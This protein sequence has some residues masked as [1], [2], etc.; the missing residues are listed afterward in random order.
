VTVPG[1]RLEGWDQPVRFGVGRA[2]EIQ[3]ELSKLKRARPLVLC[4]WR[5]ARS[6]DLRR[7]VGRLPAAEVFEGV[8]DHVPGSALANAWAAIE[9]HDA[10]AVISFGGGS[11]IDLGKSLVYLGNEGPAAFEA[12]APARVRLHPRLAHVALPTTY[13]G[14]EATRRCW[15]SDRDVR[16]SL[17]GLATRPDLVVADPELTLGL[18]A[19]PTAATGLGALAH[20]LEALCSWGTSA[21]GDAAA[22]ASAM[23]LVRLLPAVVADPGRVA[24][25][26]DL[27]A[28]SVVAGA[29]SDQGSMG[30]IH[31]VSHGLAGRSGVP[32][33]VAAAMVT[34]PALRALA[35][36][37]ADGVGAFRRAV[38]PA[39]GDSSVPTGEGDYP[40]VERMAPG[41][42]AAEAAGAADAVEDLSRRLG[43]PRKLREVGVFEEDLGVVADWVTGTELGG[44]RL[45][46]KLART[47]VLSIL[48]AAW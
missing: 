20:C 10:D 37:R 41:A 29:V 44:I 32:F 19:T 4:T 18:P 36:S 6:E 47:D 8:V 46:P 39:E 35:F 9:Q 34:P 11:T 27:L 30:L 13:S 22:V 5:R 14:A 28:A 2:E 33:G 43:L 15:L 31:V 17:G 38:A 45:P 26:A 12:G 21:A 3:V 23:S 40:T 25:R 48:S 42:R 1:Y 16:R 7:V 24:E